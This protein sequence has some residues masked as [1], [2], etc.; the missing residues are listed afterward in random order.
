MRVRTFTR[1]TTTMI[2]LRQQFMSEKRESGCTPKTLKY[3]NG[4]WDKFMLFMSVLYPNVDLLTCLSIKDLQS[5]YRV[6]I[7][8]GGCKEQTILS[9]MRGLRFRCSED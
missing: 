6:Y 2:Q 5:R 1:P 3:Y 9:H 7:E 8:D 4:V